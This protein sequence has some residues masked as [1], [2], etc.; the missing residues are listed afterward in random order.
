MKHDERH[1]HRKQGRHHEGHGGKGQKHAG[2]QTFRR[3]RALEFLQRLD[4]KRT[5]LIQQL[6]QPELKAI[7]Q[8]IAGELK[9]IEMVRNEFIDLFGLHDEN[10]IAG[11]EFE[12]NHSSAAPL[13]GESETENGESE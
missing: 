10:V 6:E 4:V 11:T 3:G 5:T 2:A 1:D 9:A 13:Q 8:V 12:E 7:H